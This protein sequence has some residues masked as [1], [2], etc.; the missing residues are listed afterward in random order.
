MA[1]DQ[2]IRIAEDG[3]A[4][5]SMTDARANLTQ[6]IREV[7]YGGRPGAFTERGKRSAYVVPPD[8]YERAV[9]DRATVAFLE[10]RAE[11]SEDDAKAPAPTNARVLR[12]ALNAAARFAVEAVRRVYLD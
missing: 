7:R 1:A 12:E 2:G 5:V 4:E 6:L 10:R 11:E 8:F 3:V 9:R